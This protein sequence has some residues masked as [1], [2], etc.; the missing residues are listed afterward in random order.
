MYLINP[1][2]E[3]IATAT[4]TQNHNHHNGLI[5]NSKPQLPE[6]FSD[7][8]GICKQTVTKV[9]MPLPYNWMHV[10][11]SS[12][13]VF[14]QKKMHC[15]TESKQRN[16]TCTHQSRNQNHKRMQSNGDVKHKRLWRSR[17][18]INTSSKVVSDQ[19]HNRKCTSQ[20]QRPAEEL[21]KVA[22]KK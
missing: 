13:L 5:M 16:H 8:T 19:Y 21:T 4:V 22:N 10:T 17:P 12:W 2:T 3:A 9:Q 18:K 15:R 14:L 6:T 1:E 11:K 7:S 20:T